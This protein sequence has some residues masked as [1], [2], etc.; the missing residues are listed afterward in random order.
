MERYVIKVKVGEEEITFE[1]GKIAKQANGAVIAR[2]GDTMVFSAVTA[3][4]KPADN[5]DFLP[6]KVDYQEKFSSAGK[7]LGGFIKREGRPSEKEILVSRLIDRPI[8]PMFEDGY[9]NETQILS[10]VWS[11]DGVNSPEPL[12]ICSAAAALT[13]SDIPLIKPVASVRV[14]LVNGHFIL[15]PTVEHQNQSKL[16]LLIAGT[17]DAVLMIEGYCDFLTEEQVIEAIELGHSGIRIICKALADWRTQIGKPKKEG[18]LRPIPKA[19]IHEVEKIL[20]PVLNAA[21]KIGDKKEREAALSDAHGKVHAQL[22]P[23]GESA[24]KYAPL[25]VTAAIKKVTSHYMRRM[26]VDEGI[27]SDGRSTKDIRRIDIEQGL[28][29]RTHGSSLFTRGETQSLAVLS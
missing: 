17:E 7:T 26:I 14:G 9:F 1:T 10:F 8:R 20:Q 16:D 29:P 13:L 15:N 22:C 19:V 21:L 2:A 5:I 18:I 6:L 3:A 24:P 4:E 25:D 23:E 12:A 28:L 11:Y 27:R